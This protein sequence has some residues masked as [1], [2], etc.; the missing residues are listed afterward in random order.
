MGKAIV[1]LGWLMLL[2]LAVVRASLNKDK[3]VVAINCG[4]QAEFKDASDV[5][6]RKDKFYQ[7]GVESEAGAQFPGQWPEL[8]DIEVYHSER[9]A[10]NADFAYELPLPPGKEDGHYVLVLKFSEVYFDGPNRKVFN[11]A[12]GSETVLYDVDIFAKVGKFAPYDE[13]IEFDIRQKTVYFH[14]SPVASALVPSKSALL[15]RFI[16][17]KKDNPK[18]NA[19]VLVKGAL[20]GTK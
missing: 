20:Q 15:V 16:K 11:V 4:S 3:V 14:N 6:Y 5:L 2:A 1:L 12:L 18:V 19:L 7:G 9:Y 8:Q 13:F 10:L 17:G